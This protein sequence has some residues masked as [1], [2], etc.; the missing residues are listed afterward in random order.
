MVECCLAITRFLFFKYYH[1]QCY[2]MF[3]PSTETEKYLQEVEHEL[4]SSI[5][6]RKKIQGWLL[7]TTSQFTSASLSLYLFQLGANLVAV[8]TLS[9]F[10]ALLPGLLDC[11]GNISI[12]SRKEWLVATPT[13]SIIKIVGGGITALTINYQ[14]WNRV[15]ISQDGI[16]Q[17]YKVIRKNDPFIEALNSSMPLILVLVILTM[18]AIRWRTKR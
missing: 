11:T 6:N 2:H 18:V 1:Y 16:D 12:S 15:K 8:Y 7:F 5:K 17:T 3:T 10:V 4:Y 9:S 13:T 14:I